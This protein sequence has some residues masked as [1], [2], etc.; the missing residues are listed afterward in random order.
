MSRS[1]RVQDNWSLQ[2]SVNLAKK[3]QANLYVLFCLH[4]EIPYPNLRHY[5]FMLEGL[6]QIDKTLSLLKIPFVIEIGTPE[7]LISK[8]VENYNISHLIVDFN[9]LKMHQKRIHELRDLLL[10]EIQEIDSQNVVPCWIASEKQEYNA[11]FFRR[12]ME[13]PPLSMAAIARTCIPVRSHL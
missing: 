9:P 11:Y 8:Y 7:K 4:T 1:Q 13:A 5:K 2:Y 10:I 3:N 6:F 12:K